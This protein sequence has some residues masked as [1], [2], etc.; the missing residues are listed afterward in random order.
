MCD[1][2]P[3]Q[4]PIKSSWTILVW[5]S[6]NNSCLHWAQDVGREQS[7]QGNTETL[8]HV[9]DCFFF[10]FFKIKFR[11]SK[12]R[13][14][15]RPGLTRSHHWFRPL[16]F[17]RSAPSHFLNLWRPKS[18]MHTYATQVLVVGVNTFF[19]V[20]HIFCPY[21][22]I[23]SPECILNVYHKTKFFHQWLVNE[24]H[25]VGRMCGNSHLLFYIYK[26]ALWYHKLIDWKLAYWR[27]LSVALAAALIS[28][29]QY[30][31]W[32]QYQI[33]L[34]WCGIAVL[35]TVRV[36]CRIMNHMTYF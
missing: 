18:Q 20:H 25:I 19:Y 2:N 12:F 36:Q 16:F 31:S 14:F 21:S 1:N 13:T 26:F 17:A 32:G 5:K 33:L 6:A 35:F 23:A 24:L 8:V 22:M 30:G 34:N 28:L 15:P 10:F 9:S 7:H 11:I 29:W 3:V 4:I 27:P